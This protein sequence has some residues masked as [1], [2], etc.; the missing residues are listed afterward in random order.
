V[1]SP[2]TVPRVTPR[3]GSRLPWKAVE[4]APWPG[5]RR[6]RADSLLPTVPVAAGSRSGDQERGPVGRPSAVGIGSHGGQ[7]HR[8]RPARVCIQLMVGAGTPEGSCIPRVPWAP[9]KLPIVRNRPGVDA[10]PYEAHV[11][12]PVA[13]P[14][15]SRAVD[16]PPEDPCPRRSPRAWRGGTP[17]RG[18]AQRSRRPS[19]SRP[20]HPARQP[21]RPRFGVCV[22]HPG[23]RA[24]QRW[25]GGACGR[26]VSGL[27]LSPRHGG[28]HRGHA[29]GLDA[30]ATGLPCVPASL[31]ERA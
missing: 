23:V 30:P 25:T 14:W 1:A 4:T 2:P 7:A 22:G 18:R 26:L 13:R 21:N 11:V 20:C 15:P 16:A 19:F 17:G 12:P 6:P 24:D 5:R 28:T 3:T 27:R 10:S 29:A 31:M 8:E 9:V